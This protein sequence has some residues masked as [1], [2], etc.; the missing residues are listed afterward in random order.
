[1]RRDIVV[2]RDHIYS[3]DSKIGV[4][5]GKPAKLMFVMKIEH[6]KGVTLSMVNTWF[7]S[8]EIVLHVSHDES[9]FFNNKLEEPRDLRFSTATK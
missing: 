9:D 3:F 1:M 5:I 2:T 4:I 6:L 8:N 7:Q